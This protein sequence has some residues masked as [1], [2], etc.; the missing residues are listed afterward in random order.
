MI[1]IWN[2]WN[3][4]Y[5]NDLANKQPKGNYQAAGSY[6]ASSHTHTFA[7][8]TSKPT[9]LSGYGITDAAAKNHNHDSKYI[10]IGSFKEIERTGLK[11]SKMSND[12]FEF[13]FPKVTGKTRII[14]NVAFHGTMSSFMN[15]I[16]TDTQD[17]G[18]LRITVSNQASSD[19]SG[20]IRVICL[21][22]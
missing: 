1:I 12:W 7:S 8:L 18:W 9:T 15:W 5:Y 21:Y 13:Q 17:N 3:N 4:N 20:N 2:I 22:L 10:A 14:C 16:A 11:V 19:F 6:A